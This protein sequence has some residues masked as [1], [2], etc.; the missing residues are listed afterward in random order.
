VEAGHRCA[1]PTCR[2]P[3]TEIA[4]IVPYS[5][6]NKH[7]HGNLIALCPNCHTRFDGG[8][9]DRSAMRMYK[10]K[11]MF[12]SDRYSAFELNLLDYLRVRPWAIVPGLIIVKGLLDDGLI[13]N[14]SKVAVIAFEGTEEV[15]SFRAGLTEKG[16]RFLQ[17]WFDP[18]N[19]ALTYGAEEPDQNPP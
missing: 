1:I 12:I 7:E 18:G 9:I 6:V 16:K 8:E 11:L 17:E 2:F 19:D 3:T 15:A 10:R 14:G 4:H 5:Q 13:E